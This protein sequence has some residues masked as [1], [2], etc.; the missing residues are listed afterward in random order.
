MTYPM[1]LLSS[2]QNQVD[3]PLSFSL[4]YTITVNEMCTVKLLLQIKI[5]IIYDTYHLNEW[6]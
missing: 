3:S 4:C 2:Y 5:R 1:R 6:L